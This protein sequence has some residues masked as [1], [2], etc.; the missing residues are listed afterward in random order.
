MK[1]VL[2][3]IIIILLLCCAICLILGVVFYDYIPTNKVIPSTV[4][5]YTTSNTIKEEINQEITEF[6]KQTIVMEIT[7][8][9]LKI[10]KQERSYDSG[11]IN[12]F[13]K[14]SSG[15][16]N[17]ENGGG[18]TTGNTNQNPDS[19]DYFFNNQSGLK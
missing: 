15:T 16:T 2:K 7:D 3:E 6:Q 14:S 4:E 8:S 1:S 11:K 5:P 19:K 10:H 9:D 18:N 13:A 12:P 17:T